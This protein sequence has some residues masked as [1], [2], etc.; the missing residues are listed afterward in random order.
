[1]YVIKQ[2]C[3]MNIAHRIYYFK[4]NWYTIKHI[5]LTRETFNSIFRYNNRLAE[6]LNNQIT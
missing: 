3:H 4:R 2:F 6:I 5:V 1:M